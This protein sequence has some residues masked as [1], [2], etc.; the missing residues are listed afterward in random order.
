MCGGGSGVE[1]ANGVVCYNETTPGS[2]AEIRCDSGFIP[3]ESSGDRICTCDGNWS[4]TRGSCVQHTQ[5]LRK[6]VM[7]ILSIVRTNHL[8]NQVTA[9]SEKTPLCC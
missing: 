6:F 1:I 4:G 5:P 3:S 8:T 9:T 7:C 2:V